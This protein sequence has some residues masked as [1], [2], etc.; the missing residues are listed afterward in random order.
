MARS[1]RRRSRRDREARRETATRVP[2]LAWRSVTNPYPPIEVLSADQVEAIHAASLDVLARIGM[3]VLSQSAR[4]RLAR[5][6]A[7]VD[8][9]ERMV[10]CD[11]AMVE[12]HV[13]LAPS[14]F[15]VKARNPARS[16]TLGGNHVNFAPVGGPSF[17]SDLD[18]GRRSGTF[19]EMCDFLR[20]LQS[21]DILHIGGTGSFEPLDLP[22]ET[23]HLDRYYAAITLHDKVWFANLLGG[24]RARDALE[25]LCIVHG[26]DY[27]ALPEHVV[28]MGNINTNSPRQLDGNMSAGL[29]ELALTGQP[30][31]ITPFT[32]LGAMA[33]TTI[34]G[35]LTQQN[36]EALLGIMLC[37]I[38]RPGTPVV[39]G[40]FTS[41]V[42]MKSGAPAFGTPEYVKATQAGAQ[43]AR[44][45]N[46]PFRS[47]NTNASNIVDAQAAYESEM[48][49]WAAV[50]GHTNLVLHAGG[51]LEGG[52]TASFEKLIVDAEMLQMMAE[53]LTPLVVDEETLAVDAIA[54]VAPG[55][56]FFG[57]SHTLARYESAFYEPLVSDWRNFE[58][59]EESGGL[60]ATERANAVWKQLL[61][62]YEPP[63]LDA[64]IREAL[65]E[66]VA[67]RKEAINAG[68]D[69]L[70]YDM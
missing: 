69:L 50:M 34:A 54:E 1:T 33:P 41:N 18:R 65:E 56:H 36:A 64:A 52:L 37:Q 9:S 30:V 46:V 11:P 66:F 70:D 22:A 45:Y 42:D 43:L 62:E 40:G 15:E 20:V 8:D 48:S 13:A 12:E 4:D 29:T 27:D 21:L 24:Y 31:V 39:Y 17:V 49:I 35:A 7:E 44:R 67:R 10:R 25:M 23:R 2:R 68:P 63:P 3:K 16:I 61:A 53:Y 47:S 28:T 60:T 59:W 51:W 5:A 38:I 32:L 58:T 57:A 19:E 55:G 6:G 14:S 26:I